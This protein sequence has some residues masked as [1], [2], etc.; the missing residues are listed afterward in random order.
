[1]HPREAR[2][3]LWTLTVPHNGLGVSRTL[4]VRLLIASVFPSHEKFSIS[5][6]TNDPV[7]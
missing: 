6:S 1:M 7:I 3:D 4:F 2:T 5:L